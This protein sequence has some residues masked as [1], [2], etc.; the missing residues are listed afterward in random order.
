MPNILRLHLISL[1]IQA[2]GITISLLMR[3]LRNLALHPSAYQ[4][5]SAAAVF[6][7]MYR[8]FREETSQVSLYALELLQTFLLSLRICHGDSNSLAAAT[9]DAASTACS[10]LLRIV[11]TKAKV[12]NKHD[13]ARKS[14][15]DLSELVEWL[16][17]QCGAVETKFRRQCMQLFTELSPQLPS[18]SGP[19]HWVSSYIE[20]NGLSALLLVFEGNIGAPPVFNTTN[21][22][23]K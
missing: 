6:S 12:L 1:Q 14:F 3:R 9:G 23:Y 20:T 10:R 18:V 7:H 13:H 17:K 5:L 8:F 21:K 11:T 2:S 15:Q 19:S 4:R 16:F 22:S